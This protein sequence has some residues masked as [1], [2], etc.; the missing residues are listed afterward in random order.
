M[1]LYGGINNVGVIFEWD[2]VTN[3]FTKKIDLNQAD[4]WHPIGTLTLNGENFT[5]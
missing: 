4:G 2:P 5:V 1:T 3:V